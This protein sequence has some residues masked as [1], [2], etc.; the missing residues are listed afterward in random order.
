MFTPYDYNE[1][2]GHRKDAIDERL[3]E[4]SPVVGLAYEGGLL[5]LTVRRAQRKIYEIYDRQM[6]SAIGMQAD[7]E[8][9]RLAVIQQAHQ[10]GFER[11]PDDVSL[12][13][14]VGFY[15]SPALKKAFGDQ[16]QG[17]PFVIRA[18]FAE[19]GRGKAGDV[20]Y[21]LNYDG[22]FRQS[23]G[24]AVIA[25]TQSAED[26]MLERIGEPETAL[27]REEALNTALLAWSVGA[28]EAL[29]TRRKADR[30][31]YD[32]INPLRDLDESEADRVFLRDEL[33][34]GTVE[35]AVLE[36]RGAR[37]SRF[38]LL[39]KDDLAAITREHR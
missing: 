39:G 21:T 9:I 12:Q 38:R 3:R 14:L 18:L 24:A 28:R 25:G 31:D 6:F 2:I 35:A 5:L 10:E 8:N 13:R 1:A 22:E 37:E 15:L 19:V 4:G 36:R 11:S 29:K 7:V 32:E 17:V 30:D 34:T 16:W 33:K 26:R 27:T 20:F 23:A